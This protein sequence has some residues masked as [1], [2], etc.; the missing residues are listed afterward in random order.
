[1]RPP[2]TFA[3]AF[4]FAL[5]VDPGL[6]RCVPT[7]ASYVINNATTWQRALS[8]HAFP[9][10][11]TWIQSSSLWVAG[12]VGGF[13]DGELRRAIDVAHEAGIE[14]WGHIG[15][16]SYGGD[17]FPEYAMRDVD[18]AELDPRW[19][20][21]GVGLCPSHPRVE[22]WTA[23]CLEDVT[24]RYDVDGFCVDHARYPQ[25]A[26]LHALIAC[27]CANCCAYIG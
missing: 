13:D 12:T 21:W 16:W 23:D 22:A 6:S 14:V 5:V 10:Q 3:F 20:A 11:L 26:N 18:G 9:P 15:L 1:M 8:H 19:K 25:P 17:V 7:Q 27:A 24:K 4:A 2:F